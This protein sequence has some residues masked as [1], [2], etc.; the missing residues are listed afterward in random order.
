[1]ILSKEQRATLV[2]LVEGDH[3]INAPILGFSDYVDQMVEA[4]NVMRG[5]LTLDANGSDNPKLMEDVLAAKTKA[6]KAC[7]AALKILGVST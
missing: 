5:V 3:L 1:M 2:H 7:A 4:R 6:H